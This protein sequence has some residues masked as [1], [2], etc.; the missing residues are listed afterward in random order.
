MDE[1]YYPAGMSWIDDEPED[2]DL[3]DEII[4]QLENLTHKE[5]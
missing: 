1:T 4:D 3:Q 5:L 2:I